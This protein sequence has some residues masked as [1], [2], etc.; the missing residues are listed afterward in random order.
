VTDIALFSYLLTTFFLIICI[1]VLILHSQPN[2][3][4][5]VVKYI[6]GPEA[7]RPFES[8]FP[9]K[10]SKNKITPGTQRRELHTT[11]V[12]SIMPR[13]FSLADLVQRVHSRL[14]Q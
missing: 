5:K 10:H 1:M 2:L 6:G 11:P 8:A 13:T 3:S 4:Q 14:R 7:L 9:N 12:H